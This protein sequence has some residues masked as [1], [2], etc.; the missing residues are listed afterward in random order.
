MG[1]VNQLRPPDICMRNV[2]TQ[3]F[4]QLSLQGLR[5]ALI[6]FQFATWKL[7][8]TGIGFSRWT[9]GEQKLSR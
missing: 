8:V 2:Y 6:A 3:F 4:L 7:P 9:G 5:H 1:V